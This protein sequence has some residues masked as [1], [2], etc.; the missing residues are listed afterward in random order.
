MKSGWD[1]SSY[2]QTSRN[3]RCEAKCAVVQSDSYLWG[4]LDEAANIQLASQRP[5][6]EPDSAGAPEGRGV[7]YMRV[8][9]ES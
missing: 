7:N 4:P 6:I 5:R 2:F 9:M 8:R 1:R 3:D